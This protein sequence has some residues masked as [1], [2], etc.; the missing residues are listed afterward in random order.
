MRTFYTEDTRNM[1]TAG[2]ARL[3]TKCVEPGQ[4]EEVFARTMDRRKELK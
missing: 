2:L 1:K 3:A 4:E